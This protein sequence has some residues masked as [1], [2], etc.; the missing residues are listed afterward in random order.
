MNKRIHIS[1]LFLIAVATGSQSAF[2]KSSSGYAPQSPSQDSP[3]SVIRTH[4][5]LSG[6]IE[7]N[8]GQLRLN[9]TNNSMREFHGEGIIA[10][11]D[12]L[13]KR[14]IGQLALALA[15]QETRLLQFSGVHASGNQFSLKIF[16]RNGTLVFYKIAAIKNVSD[17]APAVI[18]TLQPI[19]NSKRK[20]IAVSSNEK[21]EKTEKGQPSSIKPGKPAAVTAEVTI[22]GRLLAGQSETDPFVVAFEMTAPRPINDAAISITLGKFKDRKPVSIQNAGQNLTVEFKLPDQFDGERIGYELTAKNGRVIAKGELDIE[23]LMAEDS[24]TVAD[25]QTDRA[26]Y[27]PGDPVQVT[28]LLEG[29][30]PNGFRL[31]VQAKDGLGN[32]IFQ[33]QQ[34]SNANNQVN[35]Q[36]FTMTLPRELTAPVVFEFKI[37]DSETG[38][39]FDSGEREIPV[40]DAKRRP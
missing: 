5:A 16:D 13:E 36:N 40:K 30:S 3:N 15:P 11:G 39:L 20:N 27:E 23:Q 24:V 19:S 1:L 31:E 35:T 25:I 14:E 2:A 29:Q 12:D 21:D 6:G 34:Q 8:N 32:V 38:A 26:S 37:Y 28:V 4:A 10:I 9:L 22:K 17:S 18:V 7:N 33:D